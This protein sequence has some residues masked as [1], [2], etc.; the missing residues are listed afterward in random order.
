MMAL[1]ADRILSDVPRMRRYAALMLLND[2]Q[3][4]DQVVEQALQDLVANP[5]ILEG[6]ADIRPLLLRT[7]QR[8]LQSAV[9]A[10]VIGSDCDDALRP[11]R[12]RI[13][14]LLHVLAPSNSAAC[15][16]SVSMR[17]VATTVDAFG[18]IDIL[19]NNAMEPHPP[20]PLLEHDESKI[21]ALW[22]AG[23]LAALRLM[24]ACHPYLQKN[25][26]HSGG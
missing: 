11:L 6:Q 20:K 25:D 14:H 22:A 2:R 17:C 24:R 12:Q 15:V 4:G 18:R 1:D 9:V 7:V 19:I 16:F 26:V 8:H 21:A 5:A 23:P 13:Q 3:R 10:D